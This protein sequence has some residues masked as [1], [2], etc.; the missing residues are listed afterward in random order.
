MSDAVISILDE[1]DRAW[2]RQTV[3][4]DGIVRLIYGPP[5]AFRS[6]N[7]PLEVVCVGRLDT[8]IIFSGVF[9]C[10]FVVSRSATSVLVYVVAWLDCLGFVGH[11]HLL[12]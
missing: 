3:C 2:S 8:I 9:R 6:I 1:V 10:C 5:D 12:W 11:L 4:F 7:D